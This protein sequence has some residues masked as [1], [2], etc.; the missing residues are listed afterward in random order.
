MTAE[1]GEP[2]EGEVP[3]R[4]HRQINYA[5][6]TAETGFG[7]LV[8]RVDYVSMTT[9]NG[10]LLMARMKKAQGT[11]LMQVLCSPATI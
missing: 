3:Q 10:L 7:N 4:I 11:S 6:H 8:S 2:V 9:S 1:S 5:Q